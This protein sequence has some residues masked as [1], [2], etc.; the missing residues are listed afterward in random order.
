MALK[1]T[2]LIREAEAQPATSS[3]IHRRKELLIQA[4]DW[5]LLKRQH[6]LR[7]TARRLLAEATMIHPTEEGDAT[8]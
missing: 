3:G 7:A 5:A 1:A 6:R 2:K 8:N 4:R